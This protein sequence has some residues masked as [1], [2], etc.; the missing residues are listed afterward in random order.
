ML[1]AMKKLIDLK[2][3]S[4]TISIAL[5]IGYLLSVFTQLSFWACAAIVIAAILVNG[6]IIIFEKDDR[7]PGT[8]HQSR[9]Q[10]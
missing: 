5:V 8:P 6:I 4:I 1:F 3:A 2:I 9:N 10:E 7:E